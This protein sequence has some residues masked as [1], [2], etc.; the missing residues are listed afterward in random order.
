MLYINDLKQGHY[1]FWYLGCPF[2]KYITLTVHK[3]SRWE[4]DQ[5]YIVKDHSITKLSTDEKYLVYRDFK[6]D[7][8]E[9]SFKVLSNHIDSVKTHAIAFNYYPKTLRMFLSKLKS[10]EVDEKPQ[11]FNL[12]RNYNE[13]LSEKL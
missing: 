9:I 6:K 1:C 4:V 3:G 12:M 2:N 5:N 10:L 13:Y 7:G 8:K 11:T